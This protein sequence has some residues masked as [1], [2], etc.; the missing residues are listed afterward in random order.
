MVREIKGNKRLNDAGWDNQLVIV[1]SIENS[2]NYFESAFLLFIK[3][4]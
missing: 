1:D 3:T 2:S 4:Y